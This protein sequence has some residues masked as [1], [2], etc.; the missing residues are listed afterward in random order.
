MTIFPQVGT[1]RDCNSLFFDP[2]S[3]RITGE[4]LPYSLSLCLDDRTF[5]LPP[6]PMTGAEWP[7]LE[8]ARCVERGTPQRC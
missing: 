2:V 6:L 4:E 3:N 1:T 5:H 7:S 8:G